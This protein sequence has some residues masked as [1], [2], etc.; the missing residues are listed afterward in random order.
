MDCSRG[1]TRGGRNWVASSRLQLAY[2]LDYAISAQRES[3]RQCALSAPMIPTESE[4]V[5][6]HKCLSIKS[7]CHMP[8]SRLCLPNRRGYGER[9]DPARVSRVGRKIDGGACQ[10]VTSIGIGI[11]L[12]KMPSLTSKMQSV[13]NLSS[14][15]LSLMRPSALKPTPPILPTAPFFPRRLM[16]SGYLLPSALKVLPRPNAT[17]RFTTK[18]SLRL[19]LH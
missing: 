6:L 7:S 16:T 4:R 5:I 10:D 11:Q 3:P 13:P 18:N 8:T 1:R 12:N 15:S 17:T 19:L 14:Q 9:R 2:I